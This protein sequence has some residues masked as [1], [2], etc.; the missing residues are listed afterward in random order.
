MP[1]V[2]VSQALRVANDPLKA[3]GDRPDH[4]ETGR[5]KFFNPSSQTQTQAR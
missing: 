1:I 4:H 3:S 2:A 5:E